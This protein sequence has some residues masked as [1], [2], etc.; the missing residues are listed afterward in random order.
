MAA[1][2]NRW[3]RKVWKNECEKKQISLKTEVD[4]ILNEYGREVNFGNGFVDINCEGMEN[5]KQ[6]RRKLK[7]MVMGG[8]TE[9]RRRRKSRMTL[10][11]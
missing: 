9:K 6:L 8:V 10:L 11:F 7:L 5:W 2:K 3:L 1:N 4:T